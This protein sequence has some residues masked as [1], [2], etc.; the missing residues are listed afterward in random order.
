MSQYGTGMPQ[1]HKYLP[2]QRLYQWLV[3]CI[4]GRYETFRKKCA[5]RIFA[6]GRVMWPDLL[7]EMS[8]KKPHKFG[9]SPKIEISRRNVDPRVQQ[10][11]DGWVGVSL[12]NMDSHNESNCR[13]R[14]PCRSAF[15]RNRGTA[16]RPFPTERNGT[17]PVPYRAECP[18][19]KCDV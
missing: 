13:E 7:V 10:R 9:R 12:C 18:F 4:K 6:R 8:D 3:N 1:R 19:A 17:E 11:M 5:R 15:A 14:R 16:Q 2:R